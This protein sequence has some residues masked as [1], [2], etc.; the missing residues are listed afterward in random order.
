MKELIRIANELSMSEEAAIEFLNK[1]FEARELIN[2]LTGWAQTGETSESLSNAYKE[3][4]QLLSPI[5]SDCHIKAKRFITSPAQLYDPELA[6]YPRG[7]TLHWTGEWYCPKCH[8][9]VAV[10]RKWW[11]RGEKD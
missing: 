8:H 6:Q 9:L 5:C 10:G 1:A 7:N 2:I 3:L 4:D 11:I